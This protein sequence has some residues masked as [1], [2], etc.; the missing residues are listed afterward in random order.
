MPNFLRSYGIFTALL[1]VAFTICMP[2]S[3]TALGDNLLV[4]GG[5][6]GTVTIG[7]SEQRLYKLLGAPKST[8]VQPDGSISYQ[9]ETSSQQ[10]YVITYQGRVYR[11]GTKDKS[12]R[13]KEGVR[14]GASVLEVR[15][16]L[17][18]PT[19]QANILPSSPLLQMVYGQLSFL[20]QN[21][22]V[23]EMDTK[24]TPFECNN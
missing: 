7:M 16:R 1:A 21:G 13:T 14:V 24:K 10:L 19:C 20:V 9:F 4:P 6:I 12:F 3:A 15:A 11:V 23:T 8:F 22:V 18:Q 2:P 17:G 5:R